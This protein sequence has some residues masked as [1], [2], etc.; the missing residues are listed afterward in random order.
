MK[1]FFI[2]NFKI[3]LAAII[4]ALLAFAA[5]S[6]EWDSIFGGKITLRLANGVRLSFSYP[7]SF[8]AGAFYVNKTLEGAFAEAGCFKNRSP[9]KFSTYKS[10]TGNFSFQYPSAFIIDERELPGNEILC[11][12]DFHDCEK[13][14]H[15]FI[16]VWKLS[17]PL[18]EFLDKS[19]AVSQQDYKYLSSKHVTVDGVDGYYWDYVVLTANMGGFKGSEVF[20][21]KE[22]LMYRISWF[23]P[24]KLWNKE[25]A[26]IFKQIVGS[27]KVY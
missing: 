1:T 5:L 3:K 18:D 17:I 6:A 13:A 23:I 8:H 15:G 2:R 20:F 11:H 27:F 25:K 24:E 21:E 22:G 4:A 14:S 12:V 19:K 16:Q 7:S 9:E 10:L 26:K